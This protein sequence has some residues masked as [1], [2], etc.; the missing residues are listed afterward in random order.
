MARRPEDLTYTVDE[1]PP[2]HRLIVLGLQHAV[3]I[4]IYLIFVVIIA[5][6]ASEQL[7]LIQIDYEG[8]LLS[9]PNVGVKKNFLEEEAFAYGLADFLT[10]VYP[11]RFD[12]SAR[13][14][15]VTL[16]FYYNA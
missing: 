12:R 1:L 5:R 7:L 13:G 3:L 2:W 4:S 15:S 14:T 10:G 11:D 6:N 16:R 8:I 9:L